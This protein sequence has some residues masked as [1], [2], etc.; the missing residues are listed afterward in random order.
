M[1]NYVKLANT[2]KRLIEKSGRSITL[3]KRSDTPADVN[4]PWRG[5]TDATTA[6]PPA[7]PPTASTTVKAVFVQAGSESELGQLI[8]ALEL[9]KRRGNRFLVAALSTN[10]DLRQYDVIQDGNQIYS[11]EVIRFLQPGDVA[12]LYDI[13]VKR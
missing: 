11:I 8:E 6:T 10:V 1:P 9:V 2:A 4:K 13:E 7:Q 12:L 3:Y 5:P